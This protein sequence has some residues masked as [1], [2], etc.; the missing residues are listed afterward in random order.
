[1]FFYTLLFFLNHYLFIIYLF[2]ANKNSYILAF[3]DM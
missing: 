3:K 1:M 2:L